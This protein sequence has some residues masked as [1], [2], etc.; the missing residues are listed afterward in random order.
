MTTYPTRYSDR[1]G[2]EQTTILNDREALSMV[3]RGVQFRG[4]DFDG[5]EPQDVSDPAQ[6]A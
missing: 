5:F 2:A 4:T 6:L 1:S 3:V